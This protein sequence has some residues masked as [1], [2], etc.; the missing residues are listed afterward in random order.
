[1]QH[2]EKLPSLHLHELVPAM[3]SMRYNLG[4]EKTPKEDSES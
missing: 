4:I 2:D 3:S 1:M